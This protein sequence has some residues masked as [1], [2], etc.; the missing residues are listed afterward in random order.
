M[1]S[2][3]FVVDMPPPPG[4][5]EAVADALR[6]VREG[7]SSLRA[8]VTAADGD[9]EVLLEALRGAAGVADQAAAVAVAAVG[10]ARAAGSCERSAGLSVAEFLGLAARR[11]RGDARGLVRTAAVLDT[12]PV[13]AGLF[14]DGQLS[15]SQVREITGWARDL[16]VE[17]RAGLDAQVAADAAAGVRSDPDWVVDRAGDL[18]TRVRAD[19]VQRR[20]ERAI[21]TAFVAVQPRFDGGGTGYFELDAVGMATVLEGLD[22]AADAPGL[23]DADGPLP[24]RRR[25]GQLAEGFVRVAAFYLAHSGGPCADATAAAAESEDRPAPGCAHRAKPTLYAVVNAATLSGLEEDTLR[26][27]WR[28][29]GAPTRLTA[30]SA[31][32]LACDA[33]VIPVLVDTDGVLAVGEPTDS[34]PVHVRR[35]VI[36]RDGG[37][38]MPG[39]RAPAA[40][41]DAHHIIPREDG[42]PPVLTN[43]V[44]LCRRCHTRVHRR[45]WTL[46]LHDDGRLTVTRGRQSWTSH[47]R[48]GP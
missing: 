25:G 9:D 14:A 31:K 33:K 1:P 4:T 29:V 47:P 21:E 35:A 8:C 6:Q 19:L 45:G 42:G 28:M 2:V 13:T 48:A 44:L 7:L 16:R 38:R 17:D 36:V 26:L 24:P 40:W 18:V 11:T 5:P 30:T 43:L 12:L 15:Y 22:A 23:E 20:E 10:A 32:V 41:C 39:C 37:C 27:L 3:S 34:I 46:T